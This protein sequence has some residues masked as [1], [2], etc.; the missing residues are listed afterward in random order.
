ML[1]YATLQDR[2][3][4]DRTSH[5]ALRWARVERFATQAYAQGPALSIPNIA[6]LTSLSTDAVRSELTTKEIARKIYHTEDAVD[7]YLRAFDK[8]LML[9]YHKL[10]PTLMVHLLDC[11]RKLLDEYL[12]LADTYLPGED[13]IKEYLTSR[14]IPLDDVG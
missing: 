6:Y 5:A 7:A 9:K 3:L 1:D 14:G 10:P 4:V 12:Q 8:L 13:V 2:G 11:N